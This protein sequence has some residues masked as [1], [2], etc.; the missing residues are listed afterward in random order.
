MP[1]E[2]NFRQAVA[3]KPFYLPS[4]SE[5]LYVS[6]AWRV[7]ELAL[8]RMR[9]FLKMNGSCLLIIGL[10]NALT[11]D[12]DVFDAA[13]EQAEGADPG[14]P[15]ARLASDLGIPYTDA[16]PEL[17]KLSERS[18]AKVFQGEP[19]DLAGHLI[20]QGDRLVGALG[21]GM[22]QQERLRNSSTLAPM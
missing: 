21:A 12:R 20:E 17:R 5:S 22:I 2:L 15:L 4:E 9:D 11:V 19:G 10:D 6:T 7:T 13:F 8:T 14:L 16:T 1:V 3:W 18:G